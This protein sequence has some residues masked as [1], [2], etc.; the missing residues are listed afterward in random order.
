MGDQHR[1][2]ASAPHNFH[3]SVKLLGE[4]R[5]DDRAESCTWLIR[6]QLVLRDSNPVVGNRKSP[7]RF[8]RKS[9]VCSDDTKVLIEDE[10]GIPDRTHDPLAERVHIIDVDD[11]FPIGRGQRVCGK[12]RSR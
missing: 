12:R 6:I 8:S 1:R 3:T 5:D 2:A 7:A 10:K 9:A 11:Q 4:C